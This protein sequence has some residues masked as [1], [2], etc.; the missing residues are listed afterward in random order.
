MANF[1]PIEWTTHTAN[2]WHG[3]TKVHEGCDNCYANTLSKRWGRNIW[4]DEHPRRYVK[5]VWDNLSKFQKM[6]ANS[7]EHHYVF[8]GSMMDIFEKPKPIVN[9]DNSEV[10]ELN[11]INLKEMHTGHLRDHFFNTVVPNSPNLI[12]QL[13]TKR[14]SNINKY[15]PETWKSDPPVNVMFGTSPVNQETFTT[16]T[17]QLRKVNGTKFLSI[18]PQLDNI[19]EMD[20]SGIDWVIQG[21]ESGRNKRPFKIEWADNVRESCQT[22]GVPY[23]FKQIDKVQEIPK[24]YLIR[25]FPKLSTSIQVNQSI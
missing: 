6:A 7:N 4:G 9:L 11:G 17:N 2:L 13:L 24:E 18:E 23:F 20:L 1:S 5:S 3:C 25:E 12:F 14:P 19:P 15:I 10:L 16:L 21:G 22:Q 8:V